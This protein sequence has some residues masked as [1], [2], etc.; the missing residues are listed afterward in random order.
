MKRFT[1]KLMIGDVYLLWFINHKVRCNLLDRIMPFITHLG[2]AIFTI[3]FSLSLLIFGNAN[4]LGWKVAFSLSLSHLIVHIVKRKVNRPRPHTVLD[5]I[6][7]FNVP[8]CNYSFPSGHTTAAFAIANILAINM[9]T[10]KFIFAGIASLIAISRMYL[11]VH[12]PSD[13]L[14][15][16]GIATVSSIVTQHF[17]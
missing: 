15:G 1:N 10:F 8:I 13:V 3:T 9:P 7:K 4:R 12:Y 14:A 11:G 17:L 2:G 16:L 6:E 5:T